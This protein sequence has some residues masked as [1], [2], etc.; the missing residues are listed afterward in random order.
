MK[1]SGKALQDEFSEI[2]T[3]DCQY[4]TRSGSFGCTNC[5]NTLSSKR[6]LNLHIKPTR[7]I[8]EFENNKTVITNTK[9]E[10]KPEINGNIF[11]RVMASVID[12]KF[13][14]PTS[15]LQSFCQNA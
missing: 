4:Q 15:L 5:Q 2:L 13:D 1:Y 10:I 7:I 11:G 14:A 6:G 8:R 12:A 3:I 9:L